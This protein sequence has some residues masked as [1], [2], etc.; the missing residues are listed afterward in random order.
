MPFEAQGK[1]ALPGFPIWNRARLGT[2]SA[3]PAS[4]VL[5]GSLGVWDR[6]S[7]FGALRAPQDDRCMDGGTGW[8]KPPGKAS[9]TALDE[10]F[11]LT[12]FSL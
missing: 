11:F 8:R 7:S 5:Y 2:D 9:N 3:P 12:G 4:K 1:P 6:L 10:S